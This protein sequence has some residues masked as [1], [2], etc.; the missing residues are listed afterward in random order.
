ML[1]L[2]CLTHD[3][4]NLKRETIHAAIHQLLPEWYHDEGI[5]RAKNGDPIKAHTFAGPIGQS[6]KKNTPFF[7]DIRGLPE[8]EELFYKYLRDKKQYKLNNNLISVLEI[9]Q[10]A[11]HDKQT[12]NIISPII[13]RISM[14]NPTKE[15]LDNLRENQKTVFVTAEDNLDLCQELIK[16]KLSQKA[17]IFFGEKNIPKE[18]PKLFIKKYY[19]VRPKLLGNTM[20]GT[21]GIVQ[22]IGDPFWRELAYRAGL[23]ERTPYGFGVIE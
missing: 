18:K 9:I 17:I 8:F 14:F 6:I 11:Y 21:R 13:Q 2:I 15:K 16:E 20:K 10:I 5:A 19:T 12:F 23:G 4:V 7:L 1:R 3:D 22:I